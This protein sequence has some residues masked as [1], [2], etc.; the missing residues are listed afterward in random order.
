V[1]TKICAD[2]IYFD[3][4]PL[5]ADL[6]RC[7]RPVGVSPISGEPSPHKWKFCSSQRDDSWFWSRVFNTCGKG[8]RFFKERKFASEELMQSFDQMIETLKKA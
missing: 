6:S 4:F 5:S 8:G 1:K 3:R 2:C 7:T